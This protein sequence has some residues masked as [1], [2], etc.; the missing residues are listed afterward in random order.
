MGGHTRKLYAVLSSRAIYFFREPRDLDPAAYVRLEGLAVRRV[1]KGRACSFELYASGDGKGEGKGEFGRMVKL[2]DNGK[3]P[4]KSMSKH[5]SYVFSTESE[6]ETRQWL[7]A[8]RAYTLDLPMGAGTPDETPFEEGG[9]DAAEGGATAVSDTG[10][11]PT[12]LYQTR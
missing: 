9:A 1:V 3:G 2:T 11:R 5:S 8:L 6:K 12:T 4:K 7:H 10:E